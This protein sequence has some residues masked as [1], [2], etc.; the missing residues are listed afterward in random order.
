MIKVNEYFDGGVKSLGFSQQSA[1]SSVGVMAEGEYTF[2]TSSAEKMTVV[3]GALTI[4]RRDDVDWVTFQ[5]G[6]AF[7]VEGNSSFDVKVA[8]PTAYLCEYL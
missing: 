2:G 3:K 1:E 6:E 4:K 7:D 8:T 5:E